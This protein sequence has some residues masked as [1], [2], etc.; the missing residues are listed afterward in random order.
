MC[1]TTF[2][3]AIHLVHT[4][5]SASHSNEY[6]KVP[7]DAHSDTSDDEVKYFDSLERD[8]PGVESDFYNAISNPTL[9]TAKC[10]RVAVLR[11]SH[12]TFPD[13]ESGIDLMPRKI[14]WRNPRDTYADPQSSTSAASASASLEFPE[15][16]VFEDLELFKRTLE[17]FP[18]RSE[19][20]TVHRFFDKQLIV[21]ENLGRDWVETVGKAFRV[22]PHVFAHHW[23]SP[24]LC[25]R[26]RARLPLGQPAEDHFVLPYSEILP[27]ELKDSMTLLFGYNSNTLYCFL[28]FESSV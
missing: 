25:K 7:T 26:G 6:P 12:P 17:K 15:G 22:P 18:H 20:E 21:L 28:C 13:Q 24:S 23:A 10:G 4:L 2:Q 3:R 5:P 27:F 1:P 19:N 8:I 9:T 11:M 14:I 16:L